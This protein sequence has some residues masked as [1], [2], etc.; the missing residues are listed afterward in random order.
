MPYIKGKGVSDLYL[1]R[2]ARLGNKAEVHPETGDDRPRLVFE[3]EYLESLPH[4]Q[5]VRLDK[6]KNFA[7]KEILITLLCLLLIQQ[8][9]N[10]LLWFIYAGDV[11]GHYDRIAAIRTAA[12]CRIPIRH[13]RAAAGLAG[14][15]N[16]VVI[17]PF[18][19]ADSIVISLIKNFRIKRSVAIWTFQFLCLGVK[20]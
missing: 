10:D 11:A 2:I 19:T 5:W 20:L 1:I 4:N 13:D 3:L 15:D 7:F 9:R 6:D 17:F 14:I 8:E 18:F 16:D 12:G